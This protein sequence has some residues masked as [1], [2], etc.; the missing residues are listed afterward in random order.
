MPKLQVAVERLQTL[1]ERL[2]VPIERVNLE[3]HFTDF[4]ALKEVG[5][6]IKSDRFAY[7]CWRPLKTDFSLLHPDAI[8]NQAR[9]V[10]GRRRLSVVPANVLPP[11]DWGG[12]PTN[13][14]NVT[15]SELFDEPV[16]KVHREGDPLI[17]QEIGKI[18]AQTLKL[19]NALPV[20]ITL[21]MES[22]RR[23]H[24]YILSVP[25]VDA[26]KVAAEICKKFDLHD[27]VGAFEWLGNVTTIEQLVNEKDYCVTNYPAECW[28][29]NQTSF[30][31]ERTGFVNP[32]LNVF[33]SELPGVAVVIDE[34]G[35]RV[36]RSSVCRKYI[37]WKLLEGY[38]PKSQGNYVLLS[39]GKE[40]RLM[41]VGFEQ[42]ADEDPP[43][44]QFKAAV[45]PIIASMGGKL[46]PIPYI[47]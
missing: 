35:P 20:K 27:G 24:L 43:L 37:P 14:V 13:S 47:K 3:A 29:F 6:C 31:L 38:S 25:R 15:F 46:K 16:D 26:A 11:Y 18:A 8:L 9:L 41:F 21:S 2:T 12:L 4:E 40:G 36:K 23:E 5:S 44:K 34:L 7:Y 22:K 39:P 33:L 10:F 32:V 1:I 30:A 45:S 19:A 17:A 42:Y 28:S